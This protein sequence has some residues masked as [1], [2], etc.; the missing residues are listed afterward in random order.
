MPKKEA[1]SHPSRKHR[2]F[3]SLEEPHRLSVQK[4]TGILRI[5]DALD[6]S[7]RQVIKRVSC[8]LIHSD[9]VFHLVCTDECDIELWM[10]DL[11]ADLFRDVFRIPVRFEQKLLA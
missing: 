6:R 1:D 4:L 5:A 3:F 9:L 11:K 7:R 2:D 8:E 10:A